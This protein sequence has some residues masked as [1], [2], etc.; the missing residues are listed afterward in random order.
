MNHEHEQIFPQRL[1][2][3]NQPSDLIVEMDDGGLILSG[4]GIFSEGVLV[5]V[6]IADGGLMV[7]GRHDI[8]VVVCRHPL[9]GH[10]LLSL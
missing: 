5:G 4:V 3:N 1:D 9:R 8:D 10:Y 2:F 7:P 6:V